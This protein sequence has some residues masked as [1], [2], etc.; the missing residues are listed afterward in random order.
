[1]KSFKVTICAIVLACVAAIAPSSQAQTLKVLTAGSSAQF[2]PFAVAAYALAKAGGATASHF[3]FKTGGTNCGSATAGYA[4]IKDNRGANSA[5]E[6]PAN[7]WVVW[8]TNG[9]WAYA[10]VDSVVGV[11][12]FLSY[13]RASLAMSALANF[14]LTLPSNYLYWNDSTNDTAMTSTVYNALNNAT[15][16]SANTDVRPEDGLWSTNYQLSLGYS[17][18][19]PIKSYFSG[20]IANPIA[21]SLATGVA[22]PISGQTIPAANAWITYP[23]GAAP[24]LFLANTTN[25]SAAT[26]I[27][28]ANAALL[29]SGKAIGSSPACSGAAIGL[30]STIALTPVLREGLSGT[31]NTTEFTTLNPFSHSNATPQE[32][33]ISATTNNPANVACGSGFRDRGVGTGEVVKAVQRNTGLLHVATNPVGYAFFSYESVGANAAYKYLQLDNIDGLSH[34][35]GPAYSGALPSCGSG[36]GYLNCPLAANTSFAHIRDGSYRAWSI[37]RVVTDSA[38]SANTQA[39]VVEA[40]ALV[41]STIPDFVPFLPQCALVARGVNEK[42]LDVYRQHFTP[43]GIT[44]PYPGPNDGPVQPSVVCTKTVGTLPVL[45]LGGEGSSNKES[46]GDVGGRIQGPFTS[47]PTVPGATGSR[48]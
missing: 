46:G 3:T 18:T 30:A 35:G 11:R 6:E 15:I 48:Q 28:Q 14:T 43:A 45:T 25:L 8:S 39:L 34:T 47:S 41:N 24:I 16:T 17:K 10:S 12:S 9:I 7:V 37:Y 44:L 22:D 21:F 40:Q 20:G 26:N 2:G 1:M 38:H 29:F 23:V 31:Y 5:P 27:S 42:G 36:S 32:S 19:L 4:C 13:P 33:G